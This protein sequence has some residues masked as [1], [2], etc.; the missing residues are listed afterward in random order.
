M[1][2]FHSSC[3]PNGSTGTHS[4]KV[5]FV[6]LDA[7]GKKAEMVGRAATVEL[8]VEDGHLIA[9]AREYETR[10]A[11]A[12]G[13]TEIHGEET[14]YP[15]EWSKEAE[16]ADSRPKWLPSMKDL[17]LSADERK[18]LA[19][20]IPKQPEP[21]YVRYLK[22]AFGPDCEELGRRSQFYSPR[23]GV[24]LAFDRAEL[25]KDGQAEYLNVSIARFRK[26]NGKDIV[27]STVRDS[28]IVGPWIR[29]FTGNS[30]TFECESGIQIR[31]ERDR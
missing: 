25:R 12:D 8:L 3:T 21:E 31:I 29:D 30:I 24:A 5:Q 7:S 4:R 20:G 10:L 22:L 17:P 27:V 2:S 13:L 14:E 23:Y 28:K 26:E 1:A 16:A 18:F 19:E 6:R 9:R 15:I 11:G